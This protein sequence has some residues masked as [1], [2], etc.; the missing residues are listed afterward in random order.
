MQQYLEEVNDVQ[1]IQFLSV[2]QGFLNHKVLKEVDSL[3]GMYSRAADRILN[4]V[5]SAPSPIYRAALSSCC[6][7]LSF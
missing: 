3:S 2:L 7:L 1:S 6:L 4:Q 5:S